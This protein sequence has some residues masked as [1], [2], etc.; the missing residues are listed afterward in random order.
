MIKKL[1]LLMLM[2]LPCA[3]ATVKAQYGVGDWKIHATFSGQN[4][5]NIIDTG[6]KVYYLVSNNLFCYDKETQEN[7][8]LNKGNYLSD[9]L[10][11]Q[12]YYNSYKKYL[13]VVYDNSNIDIIDHDGKVFNMP[14]IKDAILTSDKTINHVSFTDKAAYVATSFGYLVLN[15]SKYEVKESRIYN[16]SMA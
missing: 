3:T 7:E 4:V 16:I 12:I 2:L 5:Q 11:K 14:D 10:I 8:N 13:L 15:D 9:V 1:F 6:D